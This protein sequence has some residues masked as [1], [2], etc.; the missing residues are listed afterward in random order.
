[1]FEAIGGLLS[2][3]WPRF[4]RVNAETS[5]YQAFVNYRRLWLTTILVLA[6]ASVAPLVVL[7]VLHNRL[8]KD[9]VR[10][11][12][13]LRTVRLASN[14]RRSV[15]HFLEERLDALD[16]TGREFRQDWILDPQQ[17]ASVLEHLKLGFGGFSD[18]GVVDAGGI[19]VAYSGPYD[20]AGRDYSRHE[21]FERCLARGI[22]ISDVFEGYRGVP[23]IVIAVRSA[24][25]Q[26]PVRVLRATLDTERL[27][28]ALETVKLAVH[29]DVFLVNRAGVIQSSSLL[30]G[31][32][33]QKAAIEV[34]P[35]SPRTQA[36]S[37]LDPQGERA[38]LGYA[39]IE[40]KYG[41]TP[42]VLLLVRREAEMMES[43]LGVG[44]ASA[45]F[46]ALS[47]LGI[48]LIVA[49]T[50]TYMINQLYRADRARGQTMLGLEEAGRLA[51]LGR[52][53]AG[54][55]HEINNP[56]AVINEE[57]GYMRDVLTLEQAGGEPV[58]RAGAPGVE[59]KEH[60]D[61][62]L[63]CVERCGL[64]TR[65]LLSFARQVDVSSEPVRVARVA[66]EILS[67]FRKEAGYRNIAV[68][69]EAPEEG[70]EIVSD[71]GKLQQV[72]FNLLNNAFQ[73]MTKDGAVTVSIDSTEDG[74]VRIAVSDTGCGIPPAHLGKIFEPFFTTKGRGAGTGLGLSITYGLVRKLKGR[75]SVESQVGVGTTV[76][77]LLPTRVQE[78]SA[79]ESAVGR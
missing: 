28:A 33:L 75:I 21:W 13:E 31:Q 8:T 12:R 73:A 25:E 48:F 53:A 30:F 59:F 51:S 40:T 19:Q 9:A 45:L 68:R 69:L 14:A 24:P 37:M 76:T 35:Y 16:F 78:A 77:I 54:V 4:W 10:V 22:Y 65:Q 62:I 63:E 66:E 44:V 2:S 3:L 6:I 15:A 64:I 67:F 70:L 57:A 27:I 11:E 5:P 39:F 50:S 32:V 60:L 23:H 20:L 43:L 58:L 71:R 34:P 61:S 42:F 38:L 26:G 46:L 72:L 79:H 55:A 41:E 49:L 7:S 17:L 74:L 29:D 56:L 1:M 36:Q 18:L 52:L 47:I